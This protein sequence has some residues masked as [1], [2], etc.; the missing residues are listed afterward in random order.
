MSTRVIASP[1][2]RRGEIT[3]SEDLERVFKYLCK[4]KPEPANI[5][6]NPWE[7]K[8][9]KGIIRGD[10]YQSSLKHDIEVEIKNKMQ[11]AD[12]LNISKNTLLTLI[13]EDFPNGSPTNA[14]TLANAKVAEYNKTMCHEHL[15]KHYENPITHDWGSGK[16]VDAMGQYLYAKYDQKDPALFTL[17]EF[18]TAKNDPSFWGANGKLKPS[19]LS[20]LKCIMKFAALQIKDS[21]LNQDRFQFVEQDEWYSAGLKNI[22]GKKDDWLQASD[23]LGQGSELERY[24]GGIEEIDTLVMHRLGLECGGRISSQLLMGTKLPNGYLCQPFWDMNKLTMF[25]PKVDGSKTGGKVTRYFV[26]ETMAFFKRYLEDSKILGAWF[27][28]FPTESQNYQSYSSS[29]KFAGLRASIWNWKYRKEGQAL[30]EGEKVASDGRIYKLVP[31]KNNQKG[32][33]DYRKE[34]QFVGKMTTSHTTMKHSFVSLAGLHGFSL[35]NCSEQ[36]GTDATTLKD[37]YHGTLDVGLQ[38]VVMGEKIYVPWLD[39]IRTFVE[40]LYTNRYNELM[41]KGKATVDLQVIAQEEAAVAEV[42]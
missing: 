41:R 8:T 33:M 15:K 24:V 39:W 11:L 42:E 23:K 3:T 5:D 12:Y 18:Q 6:T 35:D 1:K 14:K 20:H 37:W 32:T 30:A 10:K 17:E 22:G 34:W 40:P 21:P 31:V 4:A 13:Y 7:V 26:P 9:F 25:E 27:K 19:E 28:R 2:Q 29:L 16:S 38:K 36:C